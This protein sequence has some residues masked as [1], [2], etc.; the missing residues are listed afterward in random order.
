MHNKPANERTLVSKSKY[1]NKPHKQPHLTSHSVPVWLTNCYLLF[2][3]FCFLVSFTWHICFMVALLSFRFQNRST[4][5]PFALPLLA[6]SCVAVVLFFYMQLSL[7]YAQPRQ[8]ATEKVRQARERPPDRANAPRQALCLC[9]YYFGMLYISADM[10]GARPSH[11]P[12]TNIAQ[13]KANKSR[14]KREKARA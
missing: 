8:E 2:A 13:T 14:I 11:Q 4:R 6:L 3:F 1:S 9:A 12:L 10:K 7:L 5:S